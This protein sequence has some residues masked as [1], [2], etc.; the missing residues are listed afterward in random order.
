MI[1]AGKW[2]GYCEKASPE[3]LGIPEAN[4]GKGGFTVFAEMAG[5]PQGLPWCAIFVHAVLGR[6][7]VL[8]KAHPGTRVLARRMRRKKLWRERDYCPEAG[9][10]VFL[11]NPGSR[12]IDHCGIVESC[13]GESVVS[14]EGNAFD[15]RGRFPAAAGGVV[16]RRKRA[17]AD[18]RI[19]GYGAVGKMIKGD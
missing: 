8:G 3:L 6:P 11:R 9:D 5:L 13:D 17:R 18:A 4:A 2:I 12:K 16:A 19:V 14:V 1:D 15:E 7:D 10:I